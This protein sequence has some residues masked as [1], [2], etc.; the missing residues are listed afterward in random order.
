VLVD[1]NTQANYVGKASSEERP[2]QVERVAGHYSQKE[3]TGSIP[4][5]TETTLVYGNAA[6]QRVIELSLPMSPDDTIERPA[7]MGF[8]PLP[9]VTDNSWI[10]VPSVA[11]QRAQ[12]YGRVQ[13]R[14]RLGHREGLSIQI[15]PEL[16]PSIPFA[17]IYVQ[18]AG[19]T[20][21]YRA[22]G[23]S[24]TFDANGIVC[25]IDAMFWGGAGQE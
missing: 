22:N 23:S 20:G 5:R 16:M 1:H 11:A 8:P 7:G 13:N 3:G 14:M 12:A 18:A 25:S 2:K 21:Q 17:P 15:V 10:A 19:I 6:S 24:W 9:G 4:E